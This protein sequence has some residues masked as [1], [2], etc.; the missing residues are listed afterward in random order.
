MKFKRIYIEIT[1]LCNKSCSF[2][3]VDSKEKKEMSLS[4]F[5]HILK[6]IQNTTE[7]IYL[8]VKGEPLLHS[9]FKEILELANIYN[10][11]VNITTNGTLLKRQTNI[12]KSYD[13]IRQI[14]ISLHSFEDTN[15]L[16]DIYESVIQLKNNNKIS[17]IYRFWALENNTFSESNLKLINELEKLYN[18]PNIL[19]EIS[20]TNNIKIDKNT[21]INKDQ[22]FVWPNINDT[23]YEELGT[24]Y[25]LKSHIGIL[26]DG[27]VVPCCLD[28]SGISE[29]GNI[30]KENLNEILGKEKTRLIKTNFQKNLASEELCKHCSFKAKFP[31]NLINN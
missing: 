26:S 13:N 23:Y 12:L 28:S 6:Q 25:G 19:N 3:S 15:Y 30:F 21:Y 22:L 9:N 16:N 2:C 8:H 17:L 31:L 5:E 1:N 7:Y 11:K 10:L 20:N 4:E 29:L 27:T 14:N 18:N 24:C